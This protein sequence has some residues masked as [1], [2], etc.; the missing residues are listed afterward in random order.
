VLNRP[1]TTTLELLKYLFATFSTVEPDNPLE[2]S[3][4]GKVMIV[5]TSFSANLANSLFNASSDV[6][7]MLN[8]DFGRSLGGGYRP[9]PADLA[10]GSSGNGLQYVIEAAVMD[11]RIRWIQER[12]VASF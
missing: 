9:T 3:S 4:F 5:R 6:D 2:V 10:E 7:L 12:H 8:S 1:F 11:A